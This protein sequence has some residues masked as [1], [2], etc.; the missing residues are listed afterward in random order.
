MAPTTETLAGSHGD[1][2]FH[3]W[4]NPEARYIALIAHASA[5]F[6]SIQTIAQGPP[7]PRGRRRCPR[8]REL[9]RLGG[10]SGPG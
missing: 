6:G 1:Y 9:R 10:R 8:P 5:S 3:T 2:T 4:P 7:F